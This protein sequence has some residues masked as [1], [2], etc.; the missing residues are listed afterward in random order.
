MRHSPCYGG[1]LAW[2]WHAV[3]VRTFVGHTQVCFTQG[4]ARG[5]PAAAFRQI[6]LEQQKGP[7]LGWKGPEWVFFS[8]MPHLSP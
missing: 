6:P 1:G 2:G 4:L 5:G 8:K 7:G 3:G